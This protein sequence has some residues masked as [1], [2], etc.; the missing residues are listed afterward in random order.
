[1]QQANKTP[2]LLHFEARNFVLYSLSTKF[3]QNALRR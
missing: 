3:C 1:M 2:E